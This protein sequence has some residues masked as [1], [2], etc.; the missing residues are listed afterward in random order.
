MTCSSSRG[1]GNNDA[2]I[3]KSKVP[4]R[5]RVERASA[6]GADGRGSKILATIGFFSY[7]FEPFNHDALA[8]SRAGLEISPSGER[9]RELDARRYRRRHFFLL[10]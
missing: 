8:F 5:S 3:V 7:S 6:S 9:R 4:C 10:V 1:E 2:I